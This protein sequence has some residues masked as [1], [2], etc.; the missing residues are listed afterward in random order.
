[1][2]YH[3]FPDPVEPLRTLRLLRVGHERRRK[4]V[5]DAPLDVHGGSLNS[6]IA[7]PAYGDGT[8]GASTPT[9]RLS[10]SVATGPTSGAPSNANTLP[11]RAGV[12][13]I[14]RADLRYCPGFGAAVG[15]WARDDAGARWLVSGTA[16]WR[17]V[18]AHIRTGTVRPA[19]VGFQRAHPSRIDR[20][21]ALLGVLGER[22]GE[23]GLTASASVTNPP[24]VAGITTGN[25]PPRN[26]QAPCR[27]PP[28]GLSACGGGPD[29]PPRRP[30]RPARRST[31]LHCHR[32]P[33][34]RPRLPPRRRARSWGPAASTWR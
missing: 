31:A 21:P 4:G 5:D 2:S 29:T 13:A 25:T 19:A 8:E 23:Q 27:R 6:F 20:R 7:G 17:R 10:E 18:S 1:M 14:A 3:V 28:G 12:V 33:A 11:W 9:T 34:R 15:L 22:V 32:E 24:T 30:R 16:H 26:A